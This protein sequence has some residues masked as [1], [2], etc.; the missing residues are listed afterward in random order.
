M[1]QET[2][3][4]K[5]T[6]LSVLVAAAALLSTKQAAKILNVHPDS[7]ARWRQQGLPPRFVKF[8]RGRTA[9]IRYR[10]EDIQDFIEESLRQSTSD[11]G[12]GA[13]A[14]GSPETRLSQG[15]IR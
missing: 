14:R 12:I 9:V 6:N 15:L 7:M 13:K 3:S 4:K 10:P 11:T 8:G 5:P 1:E 2:P